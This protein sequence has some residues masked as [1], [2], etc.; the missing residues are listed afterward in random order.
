MSNEFPKLRARYAHL[1]GLLLPH[2]P[3]YPSQQGFPTVPQHD[4]SPHVEVVGGRYHY[5]VTERGL[6]HE[7]R[8]AQDE[9]EILY[10]LLDDVTTGI[11]LQFELENRI[12]GQDS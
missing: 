9:D 4:G 10:W 5:V 2:K 1:I 11:A 6:E 12:P 7:R 8:I 3:R